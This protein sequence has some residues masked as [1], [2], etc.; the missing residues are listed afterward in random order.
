MKGRI[1]LNRRLTRNAEL[2]MDGVQS[3][4]LESGSTLETFIF[5][6]IYLERAAN[7]TK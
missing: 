6:Y 3:V 7:I 4:G 1:Y 5:N 2:Y